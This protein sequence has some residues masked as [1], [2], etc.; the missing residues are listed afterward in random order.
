MSE[1]RRIR[2][3]LSQEGEDRNVH[4]RCKTFAG[5]QSGKTDKVG[6]IAGRIRCGAGRHSVDGAIPWLM[7]DHDHPIP[8]GS[9]GEEGQRSQEVEGFDFNAPGAAGVERGDITPVDKE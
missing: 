5:K 3:S 2:E 1:F 9:Q 6:K 8:A 4:P 7:R